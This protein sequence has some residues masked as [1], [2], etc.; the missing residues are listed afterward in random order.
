MMQTA[1]LL[2]LLLDTRILA[3]FIGLIIGL[4]PHAIRYVRSKKREEE[5]HKKE[6][7]NRKSELDSISLATAKQVSEEEKEMREALSARIETLSKQVTLLEANNN[8]LLE[9]NATLKLKVTD[10]EI[11]IARLEDRLGKGIPGPRGPRGP[12]GIK[13]K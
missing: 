11:A 10:L 1:S 13:G 7:Q 2:N 6:V 3:L 8:K 9:E 5:N 12:R 4:L